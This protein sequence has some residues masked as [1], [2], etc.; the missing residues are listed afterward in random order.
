MVVSSGLKSTAA[1]TPSRLVSRTT[2]AVGGIP[3]LEESLADARDEGPIGVPGDALVYSAPPRPLGSIAPRPR[4]RSA[5]PCR[6]TSSRTGHPAP[7]RASRWGT[8]SGS[9]AVVRN[10][11]DPWRSQTRIARSSPELYSVV[12]S[13]LNARAIAPSPSRSRSRTPPGG[14]VPDDGGPIPRRGRQRPPVVG[15][16]SDLT[17]SLWPRSSRRS[18]PGRAS[19]SRSRSG[20]SV[21]ARSVPAGPS[22]KKLLV[23]CRTPRPPTSRPASRAGARWRRRTPTTACSCTPSVRPG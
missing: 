18:R 3:D 12:S 15:E 2:S 17:W 11:F 16:A 5:A 8:H 13:G 23:V 14:D 21:T 6:T 7:A 19:S 1:N 9:T 22:S 20:G 4:R 10:R